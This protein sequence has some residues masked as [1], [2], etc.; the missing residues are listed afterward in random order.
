VRQFL[1]EN[2]DR[3]IIVPNDTT[4]RLLRMSLADGVQRAETI[5]ELANRVQEVF[6]VRRA[7]TAT[8]ART[9]A[10]SALNFAAEEGYT[11]SGVIEELDWGTS[12]D[13]FVRGSHAND[14]WSHV[15]MDRKRK[16]L[17]DLWFVPRNRGAGGE[18]L[19]RPGDP[20]GS[21]AN[22]INCRCRVL[23]VIPTTNRR[24]SR[25]R[26]PLWWDRAALEG[27]AR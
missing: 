3:A 26:K 27:H 9:E 25:D 2:V 8:I 10:L 24:S 23:P 19:R 1:K 11:Q 12:R 6:D 4:R 15:A 5:T 7:N 17:G 16:K 21:A 22:I 20:K 18:S 14:E 13:E